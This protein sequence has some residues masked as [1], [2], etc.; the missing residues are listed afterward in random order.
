MGAFDLLSL[1]NYNINY[2][3]TDSRVCDHRGFD[4]TH[5]KVNRDSIP[6]VCM[7]GYKAAAGHPV[8]LLERHF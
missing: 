2:S 7:H 1:I 6:A 3:I 8:G 4:D 5:S